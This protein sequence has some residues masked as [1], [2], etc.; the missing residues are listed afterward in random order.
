M[1]TTTQ[2]PLGEEEFLTQLYKGGE[3]LAAGR[4]VEAKSHLEVANRIHPKNEKA[5]NLLG[6]AYF[7][8]GVFDRAAEIYEALVVENP[9]D[10][11]LRVNLGLV[12]LKTNALDRSIGEFQTATDLQPDHKKAHNYLGLALAQ[13]GEYSRARQHF[14][15]AGSDAMAEKM[16]RAIANG[17]PSAP[18]TVSL[19][20]PPSAPPAP[21]QVETAPP[22]SHDVAPPPDEG[23]VAVMSEEEVPPDSEVVS[24]AD[25]VKSRGAPQGPGAAAQL[26]GAAASMSTEPLPQAGFEPKPEG[27][28]KP[29][30]PDLHGD[31][32]AQLA[33]DVVPPEPLE[34]R[35]EIPSSLSPSVGVSAALYQEEKPVTEVMADNEMPLV[36]EMPVLDA[37]LAPEEVLVSEM[38]APAAA[39]PVNRSS[40]TSSFAAPV[41]VVTRPEVVLPLPTQPVE[42]TTRPEIVVPLA[43]SATTA[44]PTVHEVKTRPEIVVPIEIR[45]EATKASAEAPP[46]AVLAPIQPPAEEDWSGVVESASITAP[47]HVAT[48]GPSTV[49]VD[50][51]QV[52]EP[53]S[54]AVP[55]INETLQSEMSSSP[56]QLPLGVPPG[57]EEQWTAA[58]A[59][60][61]QWQ[62]PLVNASWN[63]DAPSPEAMSMGNGAEGLESAAA[64]YADPGQ[65]NWQGEGPLEAMAS[66]TPAGAEDAAW[67]QEQLPHADLPLPDITPSW[68]T[69]S[70]GGG[71]TGEL[72]A[73]APHAQVDIDVPEDMH[74]AQTLRGVDVVSRDDERVSVPTSTIDPGFQQM[75]V[76]RLNDLGPSLD[77]NKADM[78]GPFHVG[79]D[80][81]AL[82]VEGELFARLT[83]LVAVVG[84]VD[85]KPEMKRA[86]GRATEWAFGEAEQQLHRCTG[87]GVVYLEAGAANFQALE[88]DEDGA[89]IREERVF[90][91]EESVAFEN[92]RLTA[93]HN[94]WL[95]LVHLKGQG[96]VMMTLAGQLKAMHIPAG[97]PLMVPL[98]RVVGWYGAVTPRL[99]SFGTQAAIELVGEG[100]ALLATPG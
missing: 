2:D 12:Y 32:G 98:A 88:L 6:L 61:Q 70:M 82:R 52:N 37:Q 86:R 10:P 60:E 18:V 49:E 39:S 7:K 16:A 78:A 69:Q 66:L 14:V 75:H 26:H 81:L 4:I 89:Y 42:V 36:E 55:A 76:P 91:F 22:P 73:V 90:A 3:L 63:G 40:T 31:W 93:D 95:D 87:H 21:T 33:S 43:V 20:P 47:A 9:S 57:Q 67:Q 17:A 94:L 30:P 62:Q 56:A 8:L 48:A 100:Y 97:R 54:P 19:S 58:P 13:A 34:E 59:G 25:L 46:Q 96:R 15:L 92:G 83:G 65:P 29:M 79:A 41:E 1:S 71:I 72:A 50:W 84:S 11:T 53:S 99:V 28:A 38:L 74:G 51:A 80:G 35:F 45:E 27:A 85:V 24:A 64:A 44:A 5:Q 77:W 23:Q 68:E